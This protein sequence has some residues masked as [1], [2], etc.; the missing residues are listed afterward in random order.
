MAFSSSGVVADEPMISMDCIERVSGN[1]RA[2]DDLELL[3]ILSA[4]LQ[5]IDILLELSGVDWG[6]HQMPSFS[7]MSSASSHTT[8]SCPSSVASK[9]RLVMADGIATSKGRPS[10]NSTCL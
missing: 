8:R 4:A 3:K 6:K 1:Q 5:L 10:R 7:N 9:V 2:C